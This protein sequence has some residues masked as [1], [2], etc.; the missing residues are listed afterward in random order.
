MC[1]WGSG[2]QRWGDRVCVL[3]GGG[4]S[5]QAGQL[6]EVCSLLSCEFQGLDSSII[7]FGPWC[8][9]LLS[10]LV[11]LIVITFRDSRRY[12]SRRTTP[13]ERLLEMKS[14]VLLIFCMC[15][16]ECAMIHVRRPEGDLE[17]VLFLHHV[18][19]GN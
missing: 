4:G 2:H 15:V 19:S 1:C 9:S 16:C 17:Y 7:H 14:Y 10:R 18:G 3:L 13:R 12:M 8:P 11:S 5:G 6:V